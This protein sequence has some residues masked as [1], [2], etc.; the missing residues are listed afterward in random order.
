M[1]SVAVCWRLQAQRYRMDS[2]KPSSFRLSA[3]M[4]P[5]L[6]TLDLPRRASYK[7]VSLAVCS[8]PVSPTDPWEDSRSPFVALVIFMTPARRVPTIKPNL[9]Q[10]PNSLPFVEKL[11]NPQNFSV[12]VRTRTVTVW[13]GVQAAGAGQAVKA[14]VNQNTAYTRQAVYV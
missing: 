4:S 7:N 5:I 1:I 13:S 6:K 8:Q 14:K 2:V 3:A 12:S 9:G 11:S 10:R